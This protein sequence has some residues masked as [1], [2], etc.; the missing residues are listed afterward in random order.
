MPRFESQPYGEYVLHDRIGCGGMA[1]IF[2]AV[3]PR[4]EVSHV[5]IKR[6]LPT[7]SEDEQ[8][9]RM[10]VEEAKLCVRLEHPN[11]VKVLRLGE[12][13]HQHFIAME[14]VDGRDL[15]KTLAACGKKRIG[16]PTDI[17][18]HIVMELLRGLDYAHALASP[19][20]HPYGIIHRDVSPS[21]IL[22]SFTGQVKIGDFG[23]AKATTRE[24]T[25]TGI[26]KGKFGYMAPE[27]VSGTDIDHRA[28]IFAAG[29]VLCELLTGHRVFAGKNDLA[30]LE[31]VRD[32]VIDPPPR[33]FRPDLAP[34]LERI[35]MKALAKRPEDRYPR[36]GD[37][38][39]DLESYVE[40]SPADVGPEHLGHFLRNLFLRSPEEQSR[41][42][43][44]GLPRVA[45]YTGDDYETGPMA[46][47]DVTSASLLE[48]EVT[49]GEDSDASFQLGDTLMG[50]PP[51]FEE[52]ESAMDAPPTAE[53]TLHEM[54]LPDDL[55]TTQF[56]GSEVEAIRRRL[57]GPRIIEDP[58]DRVLAVPRDATRLGALLGDEGPEPE[59]T[60]FG[61]LAGGPE[62]TE[63]LGGDAETQSLSADD[64]EIAQLLGGDPR[65]QRWSASEEQDATRLGPLTSEPILAADLPGLPEPSSDELDLGLDEEPLP[66]L[67][68]AA[69]HPLPHP[70][71]RGTPVEK[72]RLSEPTAP[73]LDAGVVVPRGEGIPLSGGGDP[74]SRRSG[75]DFAAA[76]PTGDLNA[77]S[78]GSRSQR[79]SLSEVVRRIRPVRE[80][81]RTQ[82]A[83]E[84][85]AFPP[86]NAETADVLPEL[87]A[88]A[89]VQDSGTR[90]FDFG[91]LLEDRRMGLATVLALI[92]ALL[93]ASLILAFSGGPNPVPPAAEA[94]ASGDVIE[95]PSTGGARVVSPEPERTTGARVVASAEP[96]ASAAP[97]IEA[98]PPPDSQE[99][100]QEPPPLPSAPETNLAE[101]PLAALPS[102]PRKTAPAETKPPAEIEAPAPAPSPPAPPAAARPR[103]AR[104]SAGRRT[105]RAERPKVTARPRGA[106][107][108][109]RCTSPVDLHVRGHGRFELSGDGE[110]F[111]KLLPPGG[112]VVTFVRDGRIV[113]RRSV[114]LLAGGGADLPCP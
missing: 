39:R 55:P 111:E 30:V 5:V 82:R 32:A 60:R 72:M 61:M 106:A 22:L 14:F 63:E 84:D 95:G 8:F 108:R 13:D 59:E 75:V 93:P 71:I 43:R 67:E 9:V 89:L 91:A 3:H 41:R 105:E 87:P 79:V 52:G 48:D 103:P 94:Q 65:A 90:R 56:S 100:L 15:L 23:I 98:P 68:S 4:G 104:S 12:I 110:V 20:G 24:K 2:L 25:A 10:F 49:Q 112:Y 114:R 102:S 27:Q 45:S 19:E 97:I 70:V 17:A 113:D 58:A 76:R 34:E 99:V 53:I 6:I 107:L 50:F 81:N 80:R 96:E 44:V 69:L 85:R 66:E 38:L 78:E 74:A 40:R 31:R 83:V 77:L 64:P 29:I 54:P 46:A 28:D 101:A 109:V 62:T 47:E 35:V 1:E 11:I 33:H 18:L 42:A 57:D 92:V 88:S 37:F 73:E 16:F 36:A 7:L 26:L 21:N 86:P 51:S